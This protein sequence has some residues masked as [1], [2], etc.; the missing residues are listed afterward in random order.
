MKNKKLLVCTFSGGR[1]SA[2]MC[3]FLNTYPK[4][5]D[6]DKVFVFANTGKE[7]EETLI[8]VDKCSKEFN[9]PIVWLEAKV[10]KKKGIATTFK[11]VDFKTA[12]RKGEPFEDMLNKYPLPTNQ[13]VS[14]CTRELKQRPM[15]KYIYSLGYSKNNTLTAIGIR[16]DEQNRISIHKEKNNIIYPLVEDIQVD[17]DFIFRFWGKQKFDLRL[18]SYESNCDLC[19]KK[20]LRTKLT[21]LKEN[22]TI[23]EWW[24]KMEKKHASV[25]Y[26][27]FDLRDHY[28]IADLLKKS[29]GKFNMSQDSNYKKYQSALFDFELD[30]STDCFC[31][32]T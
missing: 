6:Y 21:T 23:A 13:G 15:D 31:K 11:Q 2:F 4:Y 24:D 30:Y 32:A 14:N 26:K 22:P 28:S 27:T 8:F 29:K 18:K 1:T 16:N 7:R 9:L 19:M 5:K 17:Q 3:L 20:S 10:N 12:S 25:K